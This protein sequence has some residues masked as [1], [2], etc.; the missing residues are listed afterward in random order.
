MA[1]NGASEEYVGLY[2]TAVEMADRISARR[3]TANSFFLTIQTG[4][5]SFVSIA[6]SRSQGVDRV[7]VI[8]TAIVGVTLS[9][10]W[11]LLLRS[12]RDLNAAKYR[13]IQGMEAKLEA[14]IFT[15]EWEILKQDPLRAKKGPLKKWRGRYAEL[16]FAERLVPVVFAG[17]YVAASVRVVLR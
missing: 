2:K 16:G 17:V 12:Y 8:L 10:V 7:G 11:W 6:Q 4:L 3:A 9:A 14:A 15:D 5:A 1:A 13:V